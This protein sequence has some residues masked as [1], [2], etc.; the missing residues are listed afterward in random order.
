MG[1]IRSFTLDE[2]T[3]PLIVRGDSSREHQKEKIDAVG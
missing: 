2:R 1:D 3:I